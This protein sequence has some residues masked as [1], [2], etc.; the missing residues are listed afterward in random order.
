MSPRLDAAV[1]PHTTHSDRVRCHHTPPLVQPSRDLKLTPYSPE[2]SP[3]VVTSAG[4]GV[5]LAHLTRVPGTRYPVP[6]LYPSSPPVTLLN[7]PITPGYASGDSPP[8]T[9]PP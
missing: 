7:T 6:G 5:C 1:T 3:V 2:P 9:T 4:P 8:P